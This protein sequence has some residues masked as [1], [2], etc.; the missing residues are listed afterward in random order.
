M[1]MRKTAAGVLQLLAA[2]MAGV[3]IGKISAT[4]KG[5]AREKADKFYSYYTI[6]NEW[7]KIRERG[8]SLAEFFGDRGIRTIAVYGI[9][10][11][12]R[13]LQKELE[14]SSVEITY[15]IDKNAGNVRAAV[16]VYSLEDELPLV[17]AVVVTVTYDFDNIK[18]MLER[19]VKCPIIS[20]EEVVLDFELPRVV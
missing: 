10:D 6:L 2:Y 20:L 11:M 16:D 4:M 1:Q 15:A 14:G 9:A 17:D 19:Q 12:G 3:G 5:S 13:H 18:R 7:M 8:R